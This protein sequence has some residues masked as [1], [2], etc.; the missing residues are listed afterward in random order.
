MMKV[1]RKIICSIFLVTG[2]V[3][4]YAQM[5]S[6]DSIFST[7]EKNNPELK[8]YD[9]KISAYNTYATGAK[10]YDPPQVG[11][12]FFMT[13]YN[14]SMWKG[15]AMTGSP[16]MGS[17]MLSAQQM[18]T[19]PQKLNANAKYMQSM[20]NVD[21]EMKNAM[22]N[23]FFSMAKMNYYEWIV[24]NRKLMVLKESEELLNYIVKS[25]E[26]RYTY[27]MDKLNAYYKA[28]AMLGDIQNMRLM[29]EFE[30]RQ[31]MIALNILMNRNKQIVFAI[32]TTY[33]I[34]NYDQLAIDS[35]QI[36]SNRSDFKALNQD[37]NLLRSKQN[38]ER[39]KLKPDFGIKYDHMLTF[40]TQPQQFSLMAMI[41]IP[42]APWSSKMYKASV[43][44]LN[45][46]IDA[47]KYQQQ[48]LLN[49]TSGSLQSY[50]E[51][52]KSKREQLNLYG[53]NI[54]PSMRKNY[55]T[56]LIAYEQGREELFM[57]LDAWQNLK[58]IQLN[59]LDLLNELLQ[60]QVNYEKELEI[61]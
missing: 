45:F 29:I 43:A 26:I 57:V 35:S 51:Q 16:G 46:E 33:Y 9:S 8:M 47:V 56:A 50:K 61:K 54:V 4:V 10:S 6:L 52:I 38:Y 15:D 31:K 5:L 59:N 21:K 39:S 60:L 32:D 24:L 17:L 20:A 44:G 1:F 14:V 42:I 55:Q 13:P 30:T 19:N 2:S 37:I 3:N 22:R 40:G 28:K 25:T 49:N 34:R 12:G 36:I 41:T 23:E 58:L 18:I 27:G 7:I 53:K 48:T 11:G